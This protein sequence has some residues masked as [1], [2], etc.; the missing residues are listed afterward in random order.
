MIPV[1]KYLKGLARWYYYDTTHELLRFHFTE[2]FLC[3]VNLTLYGSLGQLITGRKFFKFLI[4]DSIFKVRPFDFSS[5]YV[6]VS[7]LFYDT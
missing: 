7:Y 6:L 5:Q 3:P 4:C 1:Q 2:K